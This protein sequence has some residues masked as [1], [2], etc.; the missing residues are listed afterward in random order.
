MQSLEGIGYNS[1][2]QQRMVESSYSIS[3]AQYRIPE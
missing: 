2:G 1:L 3:R